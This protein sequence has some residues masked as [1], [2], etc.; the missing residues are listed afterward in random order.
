M[1][2]TSNQ[3]SPPRKTLQNEVDFHFGKAG[4]YQYSFVVKNKTGDC[5]LPPFVNVRFI[6]CDISS[7][8]ADSTNI[9]YFLNCTFKEGTGKFTFKKSAII[10][11][12]TEFNNK[13][14]FNQCKLEF[15]D[16][17]ITQ[18]LTLK[19]V[20]F[21]KSLHCSW[22]GEGT[23]KTYGV[24]LDGSRFES[25]DDSW[26][27]WT[28]YSI[29]AKNKSFAKVTSPSEITGTNSFAW[30]DTNSGIYMS[31]LPD[32][33][34]TDTNEDALFFIDSSILEI[35]N[36]LKITSK[37]DLFYATDSKITIRGVDKLESTDNGVG[38]FVNCVVDIAQIPEI[39]A[40]DES[41]GEGFYA[42]DSDIIIKEVDKI[43]VSKN[44]LVLD[45]T[46][47]LFIGTPFDYTDTEAE[48]TVF[49]TKSDSGSS[50][51]ISNSSDAT[52]KNVKEILSKTASASAISLNSSKLSVSNC[53]S[54][55]GPGGSIFH[56]ETDSDL[57][58]DSI[59]S[60]ENTEG[61]FVF[62]LSNRCRL[63]ADN[64]VEMNSVANTVL[65]LEKGSFAIISNFETMSANGDTVKIDDS[66]LLL[67]NCTES[68]TSATT[69]AISLQTKG[70]VNLYDIPEISSDAD[71]AIFIGA[72]GCQIEI[73]NVPLI[74][75]SGY[76]IQGIAGANIT[77]DNSEVEDAT[78]DGG[79][80]VQSSVAGNYTLSMK[81]PMTIS[82]DTAISRY[83]VDY[84]GIT[85]DG[86]VTFTDSI[87]TEKASKFEGDLTAI[88]TTINSVLIETK[89]DITVTDYSVLTGLKYWAKGA[90]SIIKSAVAVFASSFEDVDL[91]HGGFSFDIGKAGDITAENSFIKTFGGSLGNV[92][93]TG[94]STLLGG[95]LEPVTISP[96]TDE[97]L[98][99]VTAFFTTGGNMGLEADETLFME[100]NK[101]NSH[102]RD[103]ALILYDTD[104]TI[105]TTNG[106]MIFSASGN[107]N[108]T[109]TGAD[110]I[111]STPSGAIDLN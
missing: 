23:E 80:S 56:L 86:D 57:L 29:R 46:S 1:A 82:G 2:D 69:K 16:C 85:F 4:G 103:T 101:L 47:F 39:L 106:D 64:V 9:L 105:Q 31:T 100:A 44:L 34:T 84:S 93:Y 65:S 74:S 28:S 78:I 6:E 36:G 96:P 87:V 104:I 18:T 54:I 7:L 50:F 77:I 37:T 75:G 35:Y 58:L 24:V 26:G 70:R 66:S 81:G 52:L 55:S 20:S 95:A 42:T 25:Y 88:G 73:K 3:E 41:R 11:E 92:S 59:Q 79:L 13:T 14:E 61:N 15:I 33:E 110:V 45:N 21:L 62:S 108:I 99:D 22:D 63:F 97:Q 102:Y 90:T 111:V 27:T 94:N 107:V 8:Q 60:I 109:S 51:D 98:G 12:A 72:P 91:S 40:E 48:G 49:T 30:A 5:K 68:I 19:D 71:S 17:D 76:G 32:M 10:A 38:E 43:T 67:K 53:Q 89:G 83:I